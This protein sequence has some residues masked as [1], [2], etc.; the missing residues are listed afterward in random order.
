MSLSWCEWVLY[1][2]TPKSVRSH[3]SMLTRL[4]EHCRRHLNSA[5]RRESQQDKVQ[6][7][8]MIHFIGTVFSLHTVCL[9]ICTHS[10]DLQLSPSVLIHLYTMTVHATSDVPL[11][12]VAN[13]NVVFQNHHRIASI[14]IIWF[15]CSTS[16]FMCFNT[17]NL[18][19][20]IQW[21]Q[22]LIL[23]KVY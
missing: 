16:D 5:F 4:R 18:T 23:G 11:H 2:V 15:W 12:I 3:H 13:N 19:F 1:E 20:H 10:T 9:I 17:E 14:G 6:L 22:F 21:K 7:W 8:A